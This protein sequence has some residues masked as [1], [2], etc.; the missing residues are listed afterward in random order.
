MRV[1]KTL[2]TGLLISSFGITV[3][4]FNNIVNEIVSFNF[5]SSFYQNTHTFIKVCVFQN[6]VNFDIKIN[7]V[8]F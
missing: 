3:C 7:G 2:L 5:D 8:C 4:V 1:S 6:I